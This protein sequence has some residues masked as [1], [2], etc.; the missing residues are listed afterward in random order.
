MLQTCSSSPPQRSYKEPGN[1][2]EV[3]PFLTA[4]STG[5]MA[6]AFLID[7]FLPSDTRGVLKRISVD[8]N[9]DLKREKEDTSRGAGADGL[10][11]EDSIK[12]EVKVNSFTASK[13]FIRHVG[14]KN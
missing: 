5:S 3:C 2:L 7:T 1:L 9:I 4:L 13:S 14:N 6:D 12:F 11:A 8:S 10:N